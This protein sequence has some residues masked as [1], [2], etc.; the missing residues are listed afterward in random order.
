MKR[1]SFL[2]THWPRSAVLR[3]WPLFLALA[4]AAAL[5]FWKLGLHAFWSDE[6]ITALYA[7]SLQSHALPYAW[8]GRN[9]Y[10]F[11]DGGTLTADMYAT[12]YPMLQFYVVLP[13]FELF[14]P[15]AAAG[16]LP[17][18]LLGLGTIALTWLLARRL[19]H[20]RLTAAFSALLLAGS[21]SFLLFSRQCR[22]YGLVMFF[23][24]LV[25]LLYQ[26][27]SL[28]RKWWIAAFIV[29]G[30]FLFHSQFLIFYGFM[31][32]VALAFFIAREDRKR[33][34]AILICGALLLALT[35]PWMLIFTRPY[36]VQQAPLSSASRFADSARLLVWFMR[37]IN[38]NAF[39]P[40]LALPLLIWAL[41]AT[42]DEHRRNVRFLIIVI[43]TQIVL[44]SAAGVQPTDISE[45]AD[46]R[47]IINLLPLMCILL[48]FTC[49]QFGIRIAEFRIFHIPHSA[50]RILGP[51][52]LCALLLGTNLLTLPS[53]PLAAG[54]PPRCHLYEYIYEITHPYKTSTELAIE[55]L[56][57]L[58][59]PDELALVAPDYQRA[60]LIF[61]LGD[62]LK[63]CGI[64]PADENRIIP[65]NR[66]TLPAYIYSAQTIPDWIVMFA[67][68][69]AFAGRPDIRAAIAARNIAY[70]RGVIPVYWQDQSRPELAWH[71]FTPWPPGSYEPKE[72]VF[73]YKRQSAE[74]R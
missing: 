71:R 32:G 46:I 33:F 13:F 67:D 15:T 17:F 68:R 57:R 61:Y 74:T 19:F 1:I 50:F 45:D 38:R 20:S 5:L 58:A 2:L 28:D 54:Q 40:V 10:C 55:Q 60:P 69:P 34:R 4:V 63:F 39:F 59:K 70:D 24:V 53:T 64:L 3:S 56:D 14:G 37:D 41:W 30:L 66:N 73:L 16:R 43:L 21:V 36:G 31:G 22:Y 6:A 27:V 18:A 9:L 29:A 47:Y 8:D 49:H 65:Q 35:V 72:E 42:T 44:V 26:R 11:A 62:K 51:L 12:T 25:L 48:G 23:T 7:R 52:L